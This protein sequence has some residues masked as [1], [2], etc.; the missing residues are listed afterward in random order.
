MDHG[1]LACIG[2]ERASESACECEC[3]S[4]S[5]CECESESE[6]ESECEWGVPRCC[7]QP[8]VLICSSSHHT[9]TH[10]RTHRETQAD[11]GTHRHRHTRT[12]TRHTH[13]L[14]HAR[15]T[16]HSR[17]HHSSLA[18]AHAHTHAHAC[19]HQ[20]S[21]QFQRVKLRAPMVR[22]PLKSLCCTRLPCLWLARLT[23]LSPS[24]GPPRPPCTSLTFNTLYD[25]T[26]K[27]PAWLRHVGRHD[28]TRRPYACRE[29]RLASLMGVADGLL[30]PIPLRHS[31]AP[32]LIPPY[33]QKKPGPR[34]KANS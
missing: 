8:R 12:Q 3:A 24:P 29:P 23:R 21:P 2:P 1:R 11:T 13:S 15:I 4:E 26:P 34:S 20:S 31:V 18:H 27:Q 17:T 16:T 10:T 33:L 19:T 32:R 6:S 25:A 7:V 14:T 28:A 30:A 5:E 9:R 22:Q